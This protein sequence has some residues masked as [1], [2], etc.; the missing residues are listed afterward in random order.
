MLFLWR[1]SKDWHPNPMVMF[2]CLPYVS[3]PWQQQLRNTNDYIPLWYF[4][5]IRYCL[6]SWSEWSCWTSFNFLWA[7]S[8]CS[9]YWQIKS[10]NL[11]TQW[12]SVRHLMGRRHSFKGNNGLRGPHTLQGI[13]ASS[14]TATSP[15]NRCPLSLSFLQWPLLFWCYSTHI[16]SC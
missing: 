12:M 2:M 10:M 11:L 1:P 13:N 15:R 9:H 7:L 4:C 16:Y 14:S 5:S 8:P 3:K 6:L